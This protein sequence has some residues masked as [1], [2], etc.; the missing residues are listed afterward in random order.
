MRMLEREPGPLDEPPALFTAEPLLQPKRSLCF[1]INVDS[2]H[3]ELSS[4]LL[5]SE[6]LMMCEVGNPPRSPSVQAGHL[7]F[8][9][10][11]ARF[12]SCSGS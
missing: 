3:F 6:Y 5:C 8:V 10:A 12:L 2:R 11:L 7:S 9:P 4:I 1:K